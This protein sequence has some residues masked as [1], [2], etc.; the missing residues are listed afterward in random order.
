MASATPT[1]EL[2]YV[3]DGKKQLP[4][5]A[6]KQARTCAKSVFLALKSFLQ[7]R[8]STSAKVWIQDK[9]NKVAEEWVDAWIPRRVKVEVVKDETEEIVKKAGA[10]NIVLLADT[11]TLLTPDAIMIAYDMIASQPLNTWISLL[12]STTTEAA[13]AEIRAIGPR[14]WKTVTA[15]VPPFPAATRGVVLQTDFEAWTDFVR[16]PTLPLLHSRQVVSPIPSLAL[17]IGQQPPPAVP[18]DRVAQMIESAN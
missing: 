6:E 10:T 14:H 15:N 1:L 9:A 11:T 3:F 7:N 4:P 2:V 17:K 13:A 8:P 16:Q 5:G 12:D 18:W